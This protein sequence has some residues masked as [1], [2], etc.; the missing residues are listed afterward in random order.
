[1]VG[2]TNVPEETPVKDSTGCVWQVSGPLGQWRR[3]SFQLMLPVAD[4][5]FVGIGPVA[6]KEDFFVHLPV[7]CFSRSFDHGVRGVV[8]GPITTGR[9]TSTRRR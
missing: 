8:A 6:G 4:H 5:A 7:Q 1:M 3:I 9:S 2:A